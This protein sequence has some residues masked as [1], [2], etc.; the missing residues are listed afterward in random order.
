MSSE[1][2]VVLIAAAA[3]A[4][5]T[6][7]ELPPAPVQPLP[8]GHKVHVAQRLTCKD[9]HEMV[10]SGDHAGFPAVSK[11]M[12]CHTTIATDRPAIVRLAEFAKKREP[13]PWK[14]VYRV[15]DYVAFN[16][17]AHVEK[18]RVGCET[19]HGPVQE[20]DAIRKEKSISMAAC[21]DCHKN[22]SAPVACDSCHEMR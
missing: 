11:C 3:V 19:C 4:A 18:A 20:R 5:Q 2:L 10:D 7:A 6:A 8:F 21:M 14:R 16:H 22:R 17:N 15:P 12:A 9:C 1:F 13:I